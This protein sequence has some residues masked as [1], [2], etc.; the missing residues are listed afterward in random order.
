[1]LQSMGSQRIG[2]GFVI[3]EQQQQKILEWETAETS[4]RRFKEGQRMPEEDTMLKFLI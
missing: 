3:N 2:Y 1:M 4:N